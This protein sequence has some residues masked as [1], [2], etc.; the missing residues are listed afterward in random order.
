M[1][2]LFWTWFGFPCWLWAMAIANCKDRTHRKNL[3]RFT[4]NVSYWCFY[5]Y[6]LM[7]VVLA[8]LLIGECHVQVGPKIRYPIHDLKVCLWFPNKQILNQETGYHLSNRAGTSIYKH[9]HAS[10]IS[11][12]T[13]I[14][15][16]HLG[17][18]TRAGN[19][20]FPATKNML[21]LI[22]WDLIMML[23]I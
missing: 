2:T 3:H 5:C 1:F 10:I 17:W 15:F 12:P 8:S 18:K 16:W 11:N 9:M 23:S 20:S 22:Q 14:P 4:I 19:A 6:I 13:T 21:P 7:W